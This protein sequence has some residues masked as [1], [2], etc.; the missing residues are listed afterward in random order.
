MCMLLSWMACWKFKSGQPP[1]KESEPRL[2]YSKYV[3]VEQISN[4]H[5]GKSY[6]N[7]FQAKRK[8]RKWTGRV[9]KISL[10]NLWHT[11]VL[12]ATTVVQFSSML[13]ILMNCHVW[14]WVATIVTL[15]TPTAIL[16][17]KIPFQWYNIFSNPQ[18]NSQ[19]RNLCS[20]PSINNFNQ[21]SY[22]GKNK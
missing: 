22:S 6:A 20:T 5:T 16:N 7:R 14:Y 21:Y 19:Q 4:K 18:N 15:H 1:Q 9:I 17:I 8:E 11:E 2:E 12:T 10:P 3:I 13:D